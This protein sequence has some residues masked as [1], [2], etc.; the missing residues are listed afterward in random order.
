VAS[1]HSYKLA[2]LLI[3]TTFGGS[4]PSE[5]NLSSHLLGNFFHYFHLR[6][7]SVFCKQRHHRF[8]FTVHIARGIVIELAE[9][10]KRTFAYEI[11]DIEFI[12]LASAAR[13]ED[14]RLVKL[15]ENG[16]TRSLS[17]ELLGTSSWG[18]EAIIRTF[19]LGEAVE[20]LKQVSPLFAEVDQVQLLGLGLTFDLITVLNL[21]VNRRHLFCNPRYDLLRITSTVILGF[22]SIVDP[23][24][25]RVA[26]NPIRDCSFLSDRVLYVVL[27]KGVRRCL[28]LH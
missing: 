20:M 2:N 21:F 13:V 1:R 28:F 11:I 6:N 22:S 3:N 8:L 10:F 17:L 18:S 9:H 24:E 27:G 26:S 25:R 14:W 23:E 12:L 7:V 4:H 19:A 15:P 5:Q 16:Q